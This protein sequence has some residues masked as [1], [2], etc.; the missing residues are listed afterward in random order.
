M[1]RK[2]TF[3]KLRENF[4]FGE[5]SSKQALKCATCNKFRHVANNCF[6]RLFEK[7]QSHVNNKLLSE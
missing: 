5:S 7:Y 4:F 3:V 2:T 1:S 6:S